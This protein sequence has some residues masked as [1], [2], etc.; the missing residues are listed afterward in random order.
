MTNE[1]IKYE[2]DRLARVVICSFKDE[3]RVLEWLEVNKDYYP[4][5]DD[6][7]AVAIKKIRRKLKRKDFNLKS[8]KQW[9]KKT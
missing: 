5:G 1:E 6:V 7:T 4:E 3:S 8:Y 2:S 9:H